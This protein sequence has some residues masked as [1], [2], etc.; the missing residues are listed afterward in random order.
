MAARNH[1]AR[2][3]GLI[4]GGIINFFRAAHAYICHLSPCLVQPQCQRI[5]QF[6]ARKAGIAPN[7][8]TFGTK[9]FNH[10]PAQSTGQRRIEYARHTAPNIIGFEA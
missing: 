8:N 3:K 2:A 4:G 6:R 7:H 1:D 10:G 9:D 5:A